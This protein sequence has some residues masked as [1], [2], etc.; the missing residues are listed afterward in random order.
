MPMQEPLTWN[1][2]GRHKRCTHEALVPPLLKIEGPDQMVRAFVVEANKAHALLADR[3]RDRSSRASPAAPSR[4]L[5]RGVALPPGCGRN[6][7][8]QPKPART[9]P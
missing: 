1:D 5:D 2:A 6:G 8:P 3:G 7:S 4:R 9:C